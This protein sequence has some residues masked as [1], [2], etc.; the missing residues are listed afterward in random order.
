MHGANASGRAFTGDHAGIL[1]YQVLYDF[2]FCSKPLSR[3]KNDG[4]KLI[5]CRITNAV[6]CLPPKNKPV[7]SEIKNCNAFLKSELEAIGNRLLILSLGRIA[8][9]AI[10]TAMDKR[11]R[12]YPFK[13][14]ASYEIDKKRRLV[15]SYHCSRYNT[16][17]GRLTEAMFRDVFEQVAILL[18]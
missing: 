13:H 17:T 14:G 8:H 3:H 5:N 1:L 2:G 11:K 9:D 7:A 18:K 10:L 6:K 16:Q 12:D 4:L 15:S